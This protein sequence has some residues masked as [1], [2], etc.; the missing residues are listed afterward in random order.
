M[1]YREH[2]YVVDAFDDVP[3]IDI[4]LKIEFNCKYLTTQTFF[5]QY[6]FMN[7]AVGTNLRNDGSFSCISGSIHS[8]T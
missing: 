2:W 7:N 5:L 4:S 1:G 3:D 8:K 6:R